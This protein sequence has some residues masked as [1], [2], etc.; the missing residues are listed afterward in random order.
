MFEYN[1]IFFSFRR[2][3]MSSLHQ[4]S[5]KYSDDVSR[6][7]DGQSDEDDEICVDETDDVTE[8]TV[9]ILSRL[10]SGRPPTTSLKKKINNI[11]N[12]RRST[13][14]FFDETRMFRGEI[15]PCKTHHSCFCRGPGGK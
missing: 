5:T 9:S 6:V 8:D 12:P 4:S 13:L 1:A 11:Q 7:D 14:F 3:L 2:I 15:D 10:H